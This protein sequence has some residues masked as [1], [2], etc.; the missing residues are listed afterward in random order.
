[1]TASLFLQLHQCLEQGG[2]TAAQH[3]DGSRIGGVDD[4]ARGQDHHHR[5]QRPVGIGRGAAHHARGVVGH[6]AANRAGDLGR[7]V[8][9][10]LASV[11]DQ[12]GIHLADG[13]PG[14]QAD[15]PSVIKDLDAAKCSADVDQHPGALGLPRQ[16]RTPRSEGH[17][18][19][20]AMG[21]GQHGPNL[22]S[23]MRPGQYPGV[24]LVVRGVDGLHQQGQRV[25]EHLIGAEGLVQ[26]SDQAGRGG[27]ELAA[28]HRTVRSGQG[29]RL[30]VVEH[31]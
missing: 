26:V 15:A 22:V 1:M 13:Q 11:P 30:E 7:R 5:F 12:A 17:W 24:D 9:P 28:S 19:V 8:W 6:H 27:L 23:R 10:Q 2:L 16:T 18:L 14:A 31:S 21:G 29:H 4:G 25:G 3:L 20:V